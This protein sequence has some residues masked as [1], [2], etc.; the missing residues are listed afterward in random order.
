MISPYST[1][2][3][4]TISTEITMLTPELAEMMRTEFVFERQRPVYAANVGSGTRRDHRIFRASSGPAGDRFCD[5][6]PRRGVPPPAGFDGDVVMSSETKQ[7]LPRQASATILP[8]DE[9]QAAQF[10]ERLRK[11]I[12]SGRHVTMAISPRVEA[13]VL[14]EF[15]TGNR[16]LNEAVIKRYAADMKNGRWLNSGEPIIFSREG[17]LNDGQHRLFASIEAGVEFTSD[18][19]FGIERAA[20]PMT[21]SHNKR[22]PS[23]VLDILGEQNTRN[24]AATLNWV[25]RYER[26]LPGSLSIGIS[27]SDI[28]AHLASHPRIRKSCEIGSRLN[29]ATRLLSPSVAA[30]AHYIFARLDES[31]ADAF[32]EFLVDGV[33]ATSRHDPKV[34]LRNKLLGNRSETAKLKDVYLLAV[35]IKAWNAFRNKREVEKLYWVVGNGTTSQQ[36][37][38]PEAI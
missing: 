4:N 32:F 9:V 29:G 38:F 33:G 24:L 21:N 27:N 3:L 12:A 13:K 16:S 31:E 5:P 34:V 20:F 10:R 7:P 19:R 18:V 11:L 17:I 6:P 23:D 1:T 28:G 35:T 14:L 26:G 2:D 25:N 37:V 30:A 15:N 22:R 36:E 8:E